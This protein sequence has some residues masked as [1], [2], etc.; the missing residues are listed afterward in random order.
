MFEPTPDD[1][2]SLRW[3]K[4]QARYVRA[5]LRGHALVTAWLPNGRVLSV[6]YVFAVLDEIVVLQGRLE[7]GSEVHFSAHPD[8]VKL[9]IRPAPEDKQCAVFAF[10]GPSRTPQPLLDCNEEETHE[11]GEEEDPL[12]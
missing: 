1:G 8:D 3:L 9:E 10:I 12:H 4:S 11:P 2:P 6:D 5:R 7:D